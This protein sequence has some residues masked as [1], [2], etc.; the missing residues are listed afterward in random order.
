MGLTPTHKSLYGLLVN[1]R[2]SARG[3]ED[4]CVSWGRGEEG[5]TEVLSDGQK[6]S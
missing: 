4:F 5:R 6:F 1:W 2:E 3:I